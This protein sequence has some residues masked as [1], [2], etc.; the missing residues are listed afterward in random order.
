MFTLQ[1]PRYY[2]SATRL[3]WFGLVLACAL[4]CGCHSNPQIAAY[5][6]PP[7][8][9]ERQVYAVNYET[10][11][12]AALGAAQM[13]DVILV[14]SD[15]NSG[16]IWAKRPVSAEN[17]G[18]HINIWVRTV[19]TNATSVQVVSRRNLPPG[20]LSEYWEHLVLL[21]IKSMVEQ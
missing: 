15:K 14:D 17:F 20:V 1:N 13:D 2:P 18:E 8:R 4:F 6:P 5:P 12:V 7:D 3:I 21:N 9:G 10:A 19:A 16:H 11:W